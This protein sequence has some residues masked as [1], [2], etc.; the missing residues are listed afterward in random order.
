MPA[1]RTAAQISAPAAAISGISAPT[2]F[3]RAPLPSC[4]A[5]FCCSPG[6]VQLQRS[7][8]GVM[9]QDTAACTQQCPQTVPTAHPHSQPPG[10]VIPTSAP[11]DAAPALANSIRGSGRLQFPF[12][13]VIREPRSLPGAKISLQFTS[14]SLPF[15]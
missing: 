10:A 13:S 3:P 15:P 6:P 2:G 5:P 7:R 11:F 14:N 12:Q 4:P 8:E 1:A 9:A